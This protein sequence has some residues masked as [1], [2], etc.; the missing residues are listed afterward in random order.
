MKNFTGSYS[1]DVEGLLKASAIS[2]VNVML[3]SP[4]GWGKT[5]M[6]LAAAD[7]ICTSAKNRIFLGLDPATPPEVVRGAYD[8]QSLVNEGKLTIIKEGTAYD[9]DA[10]VII[11]DEIW[12]S[13]D[14]VFAALIHATSDKMRNPLEVPVFWATSNTVGSSERVDALRDRFGMWAHLKPKMSV[15]DVVASQFSLDAPTWGNSLPLWKDCL[16]IR[17]QTITGKSIKAVASV[18]TT[19]GN[20]ATANN[21]PINPRR[22]TQ[23]SE[24]LARMTIYEKASTDWSTVG[25]EARNALRY[26]YPSISQDMYEKW[27]NVVNVIITDTVGEAIETYRGIAQK[28]LQ[29]IV[30]AHS[31][32][33]S[34]LLIELGRALGDAQIEL[35]KIGSGDPRAEDVIRELNGW[36]AKATKAAVNEQ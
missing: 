6:A 2:G 26:A 14:L 19:L 15:E 12:R 22:V 20:E 1:K 16:E 33:K 5:E 10:Q 36:F 7:K 30:N 21:M 34:Q 23:W 31:S 17:K 32:D 9:P 13:N 8:P 24:I 29:A 4:P 18:L 28:K 11:L 25:T 35:R 3:I 27:Q